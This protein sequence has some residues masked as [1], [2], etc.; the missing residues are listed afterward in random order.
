MKRKSNIPEWLAW[1]L[2]E[3]EELTLQ[4]ITQKIREKH[5]EKINE[6]YSSL[7]VFKRNVSH[8]LT[9]NPEFNWKENKNNDKKRGKGKIWFY[10]PTKTKLKAPEKK[11]YEEEFTQPPSPEDLFLWYDKEHILFGN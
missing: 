9:V 8:Y 7:F 1:A 3:G 10:N 11:D 6:N 2:P 4:E 5:Q